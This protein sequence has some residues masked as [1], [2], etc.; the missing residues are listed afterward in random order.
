M[1]TITLAQDRNYNSDSTSHWI[2]Y[3]RHEGPRRVATNSGCM[4]SIVLDDSSIDHF[5]A[6]RFLIVSKQSQNLDHCITDC[7]D[8][9]RWKLSVGSPGALTHYRTRRHRFRAASQ[10]TA[11]I[12]ASPA[13]G[14]PIFTVVFEL[15][16]P[17]EM[18]LNGAVQVVAMVPCSQLALDQSPLR[19]AYDR[20]HRVSPTNPSLL[21]FL[22]SNIC[23]EPLPYELRDYVLP[24]AIPVHS[25]RVLPIFGR[26]R[27]FFPLDPAIIR[28]V[29]DLAIGHRPRGWL[30]ALLAYGL[31]SKSWEH[32]L[33]L[34]FE[35]F[36]GDLSGE[37]PKVDVLDVARVL[38]RRPER[39]ALIHTLNFANYKGMS[40][41][42]TKTEDP[43][44]SGSDGW[45]AFLKILQFATSLRTVYLPTVPKM[46]MSPVVRGLSDLRDVQGCF[47]LQSALAMAD[48]Q[49]FIAKW[50]DLA[51]LAVTYWA[52]EGDVEPSSRRLT[53]NIEELS[54]YRGT[55]SGHQF[56]QFVAAPRPRLKVLR[57][58][59]VQGISNEE[60]RSFLSLA[61][62]T[63]SQI[64][65]FECPMPCSSLDEELALDAVIPMLD[66]I[67]FITAPGTHVSARILSRKIS[68]TP[69]SGDI[70]TN[71]NINCAGAETTLVQV[72]EAMKV[73]GWEMVWI[74]W[75]EGS[76]WDEALV[77]K[78]INTAKDRDVTLQCFITDT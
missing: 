46:F 39:G 34:F 77:G 24:S 75:P 60:F 28:H 14:L 41:G 7:H 76:M 19:V 48:I 72:A 70:R 11:V 29:V 49:S 5:S 50:E 12:L 56:L 1:S 33:D 8:L 71:I 62:P 23:F 6:I 22:D 37:E 43:F 13:S 15:V 61:A 47:L 25:I 38:E 40:P 10:D 21:V 73:T 35:R 53:C 45:R 4:V 59:H 27:S 2:S 78:A 31:V 57:L 36:C 44:H 58:H 30:K 67:T 16:H 20:V 74:T 9:D 69:S 18:G 51:T 54:L 55:M 65:I 32:V 3:G 68:R 52:G 64:S 63:L 66:N 17:N 26:Q 42:D